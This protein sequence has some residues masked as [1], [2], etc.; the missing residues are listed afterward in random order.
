MTEAKPPVSAASPS[1]TV[2]IC[3]HSPR[4]A[5]LDRVIA[6][7]ATQSAAPD[8]FSVLIVDN[9]SAPPLDGGTL[10]PLSRVGIP[11]RMVLE[12]I[13]GLM[14]ARL[15]AIRETDTDWILFVDDDNVLTP[16][17]VA[18]GLAFVVRNPN[19]ACVG[20]KLL[21]PDEV[22]CPKW[23]Q[24]YLPYL[25]IKDLGDEPQSGISA[26]WQE[27]E[28]PGAGLL[29]HRKVL[30]RF[31]EMVDQDRAVFALG[32]SGS[33]NLASC[34]DALLTSL[35]F[36]FGMATAY[37]PAMVLYHHIGQQRLHLRYLLRLM[38]AYGRSHVA[39]ARVRHGAVETPPYYASYPALFATLLYSLQKNASKS[40]RFAFGMA[41]YHIAGW[42]AHR[43][44]AS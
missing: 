6:S 24:P 36:G 20:G 21:L 40:L 1:A 22:L 30:E 9:A 16:S 4:M 35:A 14:R 13:P 39:L 17:F 8:R 38:A 33:G 42:R 31:A 27:W 23:A 34:D 2:C 3:T 25:G 18:E 11:A 5:L 29:C 44:E 7:I 12:P 28:P 10:D 37:N 26:E 43:S 15:R 41:A 19:V 32:R